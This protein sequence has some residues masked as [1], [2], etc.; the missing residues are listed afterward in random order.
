MADL[1]T[2]GGAEPH[3]RSDGRELLYMSVDGW[4]MSVGISANR[5]FTPSTPQ[6]VF[7]VQIPELLGPADAT[8][9][10]DGKRFVVN[11][12][13]APHTVPSIHVV[14]NWQTLLNR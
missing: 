7:Q 2:A 6:R 4:L 12:L 3:W 10:N 8:I 11:S 5:P 14:V 13:V 9:S 1:L